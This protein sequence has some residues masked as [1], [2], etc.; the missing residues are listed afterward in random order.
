MPAPDVPRRRPDRRGRARARER[1]AA[2]RRDA[3][4]VELLGAVGIPNAAARARDYPHQFSGGMRQRAMIAMA[5]VHNPDVLIADEPTTALDVTVQAQI[6]ELIDR[7]KKEF[8][9]GVILITHD[10]GVVAETATHV[11]VMYAGRA[12]EYGPA[13]EIFNARAA[14]VHVGPA[15]VDADRRAAARACSSRS[16]ARRRRCSQPPPGCA[17]HPRCKY[18]F[19]PCDKERP[20]LVPMPGGH[21][22]A[23][24]LPAE[25]KREIWSQ[26]IGVELGVR[27]MAATRSRARRAPAGPRPAGRGRAPDEALPGQAGRVRARQGRRPRG[28]GRDADRQPRRDARHRRRVRLRQVDDRAAD[29]AA[30]RA[31]R[32]ARS[33]S[34][35]RTSRASRSAQL[36]PLRREMQ[37]IFQDPYSSLN[38]RKSVGQII[39]EPFAI[40][41]TEKDAK[42]RVRELLARVGLSPEHYNRYPHEFSGGQRQRIGIARALAL[43]PKLIVCDEPVSALDVSVQAQILNLLKSLQDEFDLTYVF[44]SHDL[45]VI[46][47]V[48]DRIAV[49]YV[50]RVVETGQSELLYEHPRHP[51]TAALLSAVPRPET[52][53]AGWQAPA[54]RARR[55]RALAGRRRR[56]RAS[57]IRAARASSRATATSR[58]RCCAP[59]EGDHEAAC[60]YPVERW[61][62]TEEELAQQSV[63]GA[64][65][66]RT[67]TECAR[68]GVPNLRTLRAVARYVGF[69]WRRGNAC[70]RWMRGSRC[71]WTA[72]LSSSR[73]PRSTG[74]SRA[75]PRCR[76]IAA[77]HAALTQLAARRAARRARATGRRRARRAA[78]REKVV[79]RAAAGIRRRGR[80]AGRRARRRG[81]SRT[82]GRS[83]RAR[84]SA[85]ASLHEQRQF[86]RAELIRLEPQAVVPGEDGSAVRRARPP[87][88]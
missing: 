69:Y 42:N 70:D 36:R 86:V 34:T 60:H 1:L 78:S 76:E 65:V 67:P 47:Q 33:A 52:N 50:G 11:M 14:S 85:S 63:T 10:L 3:R 74:T 6:L 75:A 57:S 16:R 15:R 27:L 17:F 46:R 37:I 68:S 80:L 30:A 81:V 59:F 25:R 87:I 2:R 84:R 5:L 58:R 55:R 21:L 38:P 66:R 73:R 35:A 22:D 61:P 13:H 82:R 40:H 7:V 9:I 56:P 49:M 24:H 53:G 71:A 8:D 4:A 77:E 62:M 23:C 72:E 43:Q 48:S 18:R 64:R 39:G 54:D 51:Y 20:P 26:R 83:T 31:D 12:M 44:I 29:G 45:S 19:E 88:D 41:K 79:R 28:R 32:P